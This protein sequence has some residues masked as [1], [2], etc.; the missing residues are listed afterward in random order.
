M[1]ISKNYE[2]E[3]CLKN[4]KNINKTLTYNI[5]QISLKYILLLRGYLLFITDWHII[6][7]KKRIFII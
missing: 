7:V 1:K 4:E 2:I 3:Y 5:N 6:I